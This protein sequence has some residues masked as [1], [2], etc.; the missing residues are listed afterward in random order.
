MVG[1]PVAYRTGFLVD[2]LY[3]CDAGREVL[4]A[5]H[6]V[7]LGDDRLGERVERDDGLAGG[8]ILVLAHVEDRSGLGVHSLLASEDDGLVAEDLDKTALDRAC[9]AL[10]ALHA[11]RG[12]AR[13]LHSVGD[14]LGEGDAVS[15]AEL[16]ESRPVEDVALSGEQVLTVLLALYDASGDLRDVHGMLEG[17]LVLLCAGGC[18]SSDVE[19]SHGQLRTGLS[20]GLCG[21][22]SDSLTDRNRLVGRKVAAV[23]LLADAV[24]G[25]AGE[26]GPDQDS[27]DSRILDGLGLVICDLVIQRDDDLAGVRVDDVLERVVSGDPVG[28]AL[29]D[30]VTVLDG[31][32]DDTVDGSAVLLV[33][34]DVLRDVDQS[35]GEISGLCCLENNKAKKD[36]YECESYQWMYVNGTTPMTINRLEDYEY[37]RLYLNSDDTFTIKYVV[38]EDDTE[39]SEGGT[40]VKSGSTYT[41]TY[42]STPTQELSTVVKYTLE[43]GKLVREDL[44]KSPSGI[45][46]TIVQVFSK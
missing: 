45:Q 39:R 19:G 13:D 35:S 36:Y 10:L 40:Y 18:C 7:E 15:E 25:L 1:D 31:G 32:P 28:K 2:F 11:D 16:V 43:D 42:R 26:N 14:S 8:K 38:K 29:D 20:D 41:L 22:D 9:E 17:D 24:L 33:D 6:T 21:D 37:Y 27:L 34:D 4:E 3:Q 5:G 23:A 44:A 46:Y 30:L 12:V